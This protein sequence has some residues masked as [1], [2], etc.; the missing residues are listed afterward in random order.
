MKEKD[1]EKGAMVN[2]H[3]HA[4]ASPN[5]DKNAMT[6]GHAT[7]Y[8]EHKDNNGMSNGSIRSHSSFTDASPVAEPDNKTLPD[9]A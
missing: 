4:P 9:V 1:P 5:R 6:N 7:G 3:T 8:I 2:G